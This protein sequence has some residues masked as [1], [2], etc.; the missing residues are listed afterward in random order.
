MLA[1]SSAGGDL[2]S[3]VRTE[4]MLIHQSS[5]T[6]TVSLKHPSVGLAEGRGLCWMKEEVHDLVILSCQVEREF[7]ETEK[8]DPPEVSCFLVQCQIVDLQPAGKVLTVQPCRNQLTGIYLL[9]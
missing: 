8:A 9:L 3:A 1:G 4:V 5:G 7:S 6:G 2:G